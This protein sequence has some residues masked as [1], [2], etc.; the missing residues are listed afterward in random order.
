[1]TPQ[2]RLCAAGELVMSERSFPMLDGP[3]ITWETAGVIF[4]LYSGLY[5]KKQ[6]LKKI[7]SRGGFGWDEIPFFCK[8]YDKK[9]GEDALHRV[10]HSPAPRPTISIGDD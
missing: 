2:A 8:K 5:G 3:S 10:I 1:M 6:S 7:A 9:F 4:V